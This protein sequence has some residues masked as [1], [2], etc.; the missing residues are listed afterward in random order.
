MT[1][2]QI[3]NNIFP[4]EIGTFSQ[5]QEQAKRVKENNCAKAKG[6][7]HKIYWK[8]EKLEKETH[9]DF[10]KNLS[11]KR[12]ISIPSKSAPSLNASDVQMSG[13]NYLLFACPANVTIA[14]LLFDAALQQEVSLFVS[15]LE[16]SES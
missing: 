16:S 8:F 3:A 9:H 10:D 2:Y 1:L 13:R 6:L 11:Q 5:I 4:E 12:L 7:S 15:L 14:A